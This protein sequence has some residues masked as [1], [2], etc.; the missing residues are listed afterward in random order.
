MFKDLGIFKLHSDNDPSLKQGLQYDQYRKNDLDATSYQLIQQSTTRNLNSIVEAMKSGNS[1]NGSEAASNNAP[2]LAAISELDTTFQKLMAE[3][4][5]TLKIVNEEAVNRE[6]TYG[7]AKNLYGKV[8][9]NVDAENV[10]VN[11]YGYTHK[12]SNDAWK[13]NAK[14]CPTNPVTD[15]GGL[16]KLPSGPAM[17]VGQACG[18]AG[19]NVQNKDTGEMAW[20]DIQG[21][22]HVYS[23][24]IWD[25][26]S[27]NC[28]HRDTIKLSDSQYNAIPSGSSMTAAN[29][30]MDLD[31]DP[32][33]YDKLTKLN[34]QLAGLAL[35][36]MGEIDKLQV[37]DSLLH[38]E[39]QKQRSELNSYIDNLSSDR[40][41]LVKLDN[42]Y[43]T[44]VAQ[45]ESSG[46]KYTANNYELIAWT[47]AA[48]AVGSITF[49]QIMKTK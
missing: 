10:Y 27:S 18:A 22:K 33:L 42:D 31:V 4:T 32:A 15:N 19:R 46:L 11:D 44:I 47:L 37:T 45:Q 25:K 28:Q 17:G 6:K 34:K 38:A 20:V 23:A 30:C 40:T 16:S 36:M 13:N 39:L 1:N 49:H 5:A 3:Y 29:N 43:N 24:D 26:R 41:A 12:Y 9:Q 2:G 21:I 14:G 48:L 8:V 35:E 7:V